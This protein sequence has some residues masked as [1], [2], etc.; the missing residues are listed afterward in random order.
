MSARLP[1]QV[2]SQSSRQTHD[3]NRSM[4]RTLQ[5]RVSQPLQSM[6]WSKLAWTSRYGCACAFQDGCCQTLMLSICCFFSYKPPDGTSTAGNWY[7]IRDTCPVGT[8]MPASTQRDARWCWPHERGIPTR[9]RNQHLQ[10]I[11]QCQYQSQKEGNT[12]TDSVHIL[13][14]PDLVVLPLSEGYC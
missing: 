1:E 2:T 14:N 7:Y 8:R 9:P 6:P 4:R 3:P 12:L 13:N 5:H 11:R 10:D